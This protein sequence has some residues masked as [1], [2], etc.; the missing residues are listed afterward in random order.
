MILNAINISKNIKN[1]KNKRKILN[2]LNLIINEGDSI[3]IKGRSGSGKTTLLN[4]LG[5]MTLADSGNLLFRDCNLDKVTL[6]N[7]SCYRR[8]HIGFITQSFNLLDD[9]NVFENIA[10]PLYYDKLDKENVK[11]IVISTLRKLDMESFANREIKTLSGGEKQRIAI[12]RAIVKNPDI[13]LADEPT[14]S[15][16][17]DTEESILSIFRELR[18][19]GIT[20]IIVTHDSNV[21]NSC[22]IIYNLKDGK[23]YKE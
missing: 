21:A 22:D 10:L 4:I 15:L 2:N 13:I 19:D 1:G 5:G 12:A 17:E 16:D 14:G 6:D 8:N 11:N 23:L 18:K 20:L 7:L 3:A 9:R